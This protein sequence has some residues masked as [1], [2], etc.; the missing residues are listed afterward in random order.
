MKRIDWQH[1]LLLAL[2]LGAATLGALKPQVAMYT[3]AFQSALVGM[4]I[5]KY[6]PLLGPGAKDAP[7]TS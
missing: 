5:L 6:S 3:G 4:G 2:A 1:V 7:P